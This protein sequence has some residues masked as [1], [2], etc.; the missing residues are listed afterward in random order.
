[1]IKKYKFSI[2]VFSFSAYFDK[3]E[4]WWDL[5]RWTETSVAEVIYQ[6]SCNKQKH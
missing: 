1:M 6:D 5:V 2:F 4:V 3:N